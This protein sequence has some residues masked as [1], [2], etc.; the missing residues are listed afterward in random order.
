MALITINTADANELFKS[1]EFPVLKSGKH[2]FVVANK[3]QLSIKE[4][5]GNKFIKL[6]AR[7]QDDGSDKGIPIYHNFMVIDAPQTEGQATAKKIHDAQFAQFV[8]SC[9]VK[10]VEQIKACEPIDL[11]AFEGKFFSAVTSITNEPVYPQEL[12]DQGRPVKKPRARIK[13]FL[14]EAEKKA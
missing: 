9:G 10:T 6:E 12:D 5:N 11:D 4:D 3:L 13:Q 7:C 8:V 2:L 1:P 14:Y